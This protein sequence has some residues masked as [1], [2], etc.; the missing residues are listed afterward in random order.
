MQFTTCFDITVDDLDHCDRILGDTNA[1][2]GMYCCSV[3]T[4][5]DNIKIDGLTFGLNNSIANY[6]NPYLS[7]FYAIASSN[8]IFRNAGTRSVPLRVASATFAPQY[9]SHDAGTNINIKFQQIYLE[10]TRTNVYL[11]VNTSKNITF[12]QVHGTTGAIQT[13]SLET[14]SKGNRG[15]SNSITAGTAVYGSHVF[16]MFTGDTTGVLWWAMN[17]PTDFSEDYVSLSLAGET[18][19]FTSAGQISMPN[20]ND[21]LIIEMPYYA[22]GHT[23]FAN[24]APTLT[25]TGTANFTYEY[26]IDI[27]DGTGFTDEYEVLNGENLSGES[28]DPARGFKLK[29]KITCI[30]AVN[31]SAITY[32][33][34]NTISS[35]AA[36]SD[37]QYP[38]DVASPTLTLTGLESDVNIVLFNEDYSHILDRKILASNVYMYPYTWDSSSGDTNVKIL[39]WKSDKT[40]IILSLTLT[41]ENQSAPIS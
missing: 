34:I 6:C 38:L 24:E 33:R 18:G 2:S 17:E 10:H 29:L 32:V 3:L 20:I 15:A 22:I 26:D 13:L 16:D 23:G 25:G 39:I 8:I 4:S 30:N 11:T 9:A 37:T 19:G 21:T 28:I 27:N 12:E 36:Q 7:P 40:P 14:L 1:T 41:D 5:S 31:T 35:L